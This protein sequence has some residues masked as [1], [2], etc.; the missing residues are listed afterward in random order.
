MATEPEARKYSV[1]YPGGAVTA[2]MAALELLFGTLNPVWPPSPGLTPAGNRK[3]YKS[4][5]ASNSSPGE[6][7]RL[8]FTDGAV[9]TYRITG[10]H[11][12]FI[13]T[14]LRR[15]GGGNIESMVSERGT[16]YM[17]DIPDLVGP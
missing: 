17:K 6:A 5:Q 10:A 3:R 15:G 1:G 16:D 7:I 2:S 9:W 4:R 13:N 12:D 14:V 8:R 11:L